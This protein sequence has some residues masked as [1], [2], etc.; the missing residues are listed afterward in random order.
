MDAEFERIACNV[1]RIVGSPRLPEGTRC[2]LSN[3]HNVATSLGLSFGNHARTPKRL[4][5]A[6]LGSHIVMAS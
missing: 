4:A 5:V 6:V 2:G 3:A 1:K